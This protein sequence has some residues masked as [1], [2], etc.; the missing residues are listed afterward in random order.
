MLNN[1]VFASRLTQEECCALAG[2]PF[3]FVTD[4]SKYN[5]NNIYFSALGEQPQNGPAAADFNVVRVRTQT[6][7][8]ERYRAVSR[9]VEGKHG[10]SFLQPRSTVVIAA[11]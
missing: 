5:P 3:A 2:F 1:N 7:D 11:I 10:L 4:S 6:E 9:K 8:F